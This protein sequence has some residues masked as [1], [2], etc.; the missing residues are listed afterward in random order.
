MIRKARLWRLSAPNPTRQRDEP[1]NVGGR[2]IDLLSRILF[3]GDTHEALWTLIALR[4][5][6]SMPDLL[7][8]TTQAMLSS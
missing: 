2:I 3:K 5:P 8:T 7:L 6:S 4:S 1:S